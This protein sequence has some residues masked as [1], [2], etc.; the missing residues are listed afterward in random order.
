MPTTPTN[1]AGVDGG[2]MEAVSAEGGMDDSGVSIIVKLRVDLSI[3]G[4]S[5]SL[6]LFFPCA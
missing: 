6:K 1:G 3:L 2:D 4:V 5:L